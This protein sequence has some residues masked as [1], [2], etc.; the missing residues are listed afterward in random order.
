MANTDVVQCAACHGEGGYRERVL[1]D[2]SGPWDSCGYCK[3]AGRTT[4]LMNAWLMRW[5]RDPYYLPAETAYTA[6]QAAMAKM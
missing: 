2:G 6:H 5:A 3:G 4:K 1:E